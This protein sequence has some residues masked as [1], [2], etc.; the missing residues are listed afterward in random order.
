[1]STIKLKLPVNCFVHALIMENT[2]AS[3]IMAG[4]L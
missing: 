2:M 1:M 3:L 4:K